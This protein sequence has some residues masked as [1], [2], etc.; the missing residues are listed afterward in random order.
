MNRSKKKDSVME[1]KLLSLFHEDGILDLMAGVMVLLFGLVTHFEAMG[2]ISLIAIPGTFY[3]PLKERITFPRI[4]LI[5]FSSERENRRKFQLSFLFGAVFLLGVITFYIGN[6][7]LPSSIAAFLQRNM[8]LVFVA[9]FWVVIYAVGVFLKNQRFH[10][11]SALWLGLI[12]ASQLLG[13][14]MN[15]AMIGLGIVMMGVSVWLMVRFVQC[16]AID[17][18]GGES[19]ESE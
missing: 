9:V 19:N 12:V 14:E 15:V 16:Y 5:R 18:E 13:F 6:I 2:F 8:F 17:D 11:Y 3:F 10:Y 7:E 4:G 1:R